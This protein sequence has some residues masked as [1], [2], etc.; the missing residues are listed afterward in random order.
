MCFADRQPKDKTFQVCLGDWLE[1]PVQLDAPAEARA[2]VAHED[3]G[4]EFLM[5]R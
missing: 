3:K 4:F 2:E 5:K 1:E